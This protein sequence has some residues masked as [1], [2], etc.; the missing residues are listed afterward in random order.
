MR[1]WI[2]VLWQASFLIIAGVLY[3]L[4]VL[5]RWNELTGDWSHG[6]G[7]AMR[8][9]TG[10][11]IGLAALP[12]TLTLVKTRK[13]EYGTP[14]LALSLRVW[15]IVLHVLAGVLIA[16][17]AIAEIWLSLDNVGQWL[18]GIYGAAAAIALLGALGFYLAYVAELPPPPPKPLKP[19]GRKRGRGRRKAAE[20]ESPDAESQDADAD[21]ALVTSD[22][23]V[24]E[25]APISDSEESDGATETVEAPLPAGATEITEAQEATE[26]TETTAEA[27]TAAE[28][29]DDATAEQ[30]GK[31][32]NRRPS[33]KTSARLRRRS[34][35]GVAVED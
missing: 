8:I 27:E 26:V 28:D 19:K 20:A 24:V 14:A 17:A 29:H 9:V 16:G 35:G 10:V 3:F 13:P 33:G 6:L 2:A 21:D 30:S 31:L 22:Q 18:F 12:V 1:R 4:F 23:D 7:T 15:S 34:R 32:R 25:D 11:L 5:P